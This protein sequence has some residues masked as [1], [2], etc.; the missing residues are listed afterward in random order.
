M[1]MTTRTL[2]KTFLE[3]MP[4]I[5]I[6]LTPDQAAHASVL[7]YQADQQAHFDS[8][9]AQVAEEPQQD[10]YQCQV[11][12]CIKFSNNAVCGR[13]YADAKRPVERQLEYAKA[14]IRTF[15]QY[16]N[17]GACAEHEALFK[18]GTVANANRRMINHATL[19][20]EWIT[21]DNP[22]G[23]N[24]PS[25]QNGR[26]DET[27]AKENA[28][29]A[30]R[31]VYDL[32]NMLRRFIELTR[33]NTA[34]QRTLGIMSPEATARVLLELETHGKMAEEWLTTDSEERK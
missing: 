30:R 24:P 28:A 25:P 4:N 17:E 18:P 11:C 9:H 22:E 29:K 32:K 21:S 1:P 15:I 23:M 6:N 8:S 16:I 31:R 33:R 26:S 5:G 7:L 19:S 27:F 14:I 13:C 20:H 12:S 3:I 2:I 34:A 10:P